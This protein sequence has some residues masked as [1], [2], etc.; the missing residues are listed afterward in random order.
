METQ[1]L[2]HFIMDA[3]KRFATQQGLDPAV[4]APHPTFGIEPPKD[5]NHGDL[6]TNVCLIY[7]KTFKGSPKTVGEFLKNQL[8][9]FE[10]V[11]QVDLAGPGFINIWFKKTYWY[12]VL[13]ALLQAKDYGASALGQ[14]KTV[15]L[16]YV[17]ANPT[18]PLHAGHGR[19]AI[20]ADVL[21]NVLEKVGYR[22]IREYYIN[23][24]GNQANILAR[25]TY[26]RYQEALG[27][28]IPDIPEGYYPGA[29]LKDVA[30]A[31]VARDGERWLDK[32]EAV[33][34]DPI[35]RFAVDFLMTE[36]RID[37]ARVG[38]SQEVFSSEHA[39]HLSGA[40]DEAVFQL[41]QQGLVYEGI[42]ERPQG[43]QED[44]WE[45]VPL[46][47]F[48]S[49]LFGDDRDRPLKK[50]D[51]TWT[52]FAGDIAYHLDKVRRGATQLINVWGA[53][54]GSHVKRMAAAVK[55]LTQDQTNL[56]VIL[57]QT[58]NFFD[59]GKPIKMS[60]RAGTFVT[61]RDIEEQLG[62]DVLR[63]MMLTRKPDTHFDFD[64]A[65]AVEQSK[66]NPV[67]YVQY[68]HARGRSVLR[69][70][71]EQFPHWDISLPS[72]AEHSLE[73]LTDPAELALIKR[74]ADWTRQVEGAALAHEPHRLVNYLYDVAASFHALWSKGK[75]E[76]LLR[77][78]IP[79]NEMVSKA[80]L[81][82]VSAMLVVIQSGLHLFGVQ[83]VEEMRA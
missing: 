40:L 47:L 3:L 11:E 65:K 73:T 33:W 9:S 55:A 16:E 36:I 44:D 50:S 72:L 38:I 26:L 75:Q 24:A 7:A 43:H 68:A 56:H 57:C 61:L 51:G 63:F 54:H 66:D 37:L 22:V 1:A 59:Q 49:T 60:K 21:A 5:L 14:G 48:R 35:R 83:P 39:L 69:M 74:L 42:L 10:A 82:L 53:D 70:A 2:R 4:V 31:L 13:K 52:Y 32:P 79:E 45:P 30:D 19:V 6:T 80:R 41:E 64:F 8:E 15:N 18:G 23:D 67:F 81:A 27:I 76:A 77:F 71:K 12:Q 28:V 29:Y 34:L 17:S 62:K 46:P 58:V 25:S 78:L 20:I